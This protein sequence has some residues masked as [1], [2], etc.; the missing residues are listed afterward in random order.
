MGRTPSLLKMER[1]V[2]MS[3]NINKCVPRGVGIDIGEAPQ[4]ACVLPVK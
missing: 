2:G 1:E 4:D 3:L